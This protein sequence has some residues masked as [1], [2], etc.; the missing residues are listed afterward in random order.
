MILDTN[1]LLL[2]ERSPLVEASPGFTFIRLQGLI[3]GPVSISIPNAKA[4][5][6][7]LNS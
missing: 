1:Y 4:A 3:H 2:K 7:H 6:R 5:E